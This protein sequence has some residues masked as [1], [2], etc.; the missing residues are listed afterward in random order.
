MSIDRRAALLPVLAVSLAALA[1]WALTI[2]S[3]HIA[4]GRVLEAIW[5]P[6]EGRED[7]VVWTVRV[8]RIVAAIAVGAALATAGAIMQAVTGNPLAEPGLLGVNAGASFAVVMTIALIDGVAVEALVWAA[9]IGAGLASVVVYALGSAGRSGPTPVK[10][11]LAGVVITTFLGSITAAI[12][13]LE[14]QTLDAVRLWTAGSLRGRTLSDIT[15]VLPYILLALAA[16]MLTRSQYTA[17]SL[18]SS[19]A[20]GLGQNQAVWR[21]ISA[22]IVVGLAGGSVAIAGPVGFVGL[23]APHLARLW[24]G[25]DYR[26][27]LPF[28]AAGG[29]LLT[30]AA[31]AMPRALLNQD[32]PIGVTLALVG[33][34][35]FIWL[36]RRRSGQQT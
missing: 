18:G 10:L 3:S 16:A 21:G 35:Y 34:P 27:I 9:F 28:S 36:V 8:P 31:D 4:V 7:L 24:V 5:N 17:L 13:I 19:I 25:A 32:V 33:A 26:W 12:L 11:V 20:Q 23:V 14:A 15:P 22:V 1:I 29:A 6:G 2:G 30:L